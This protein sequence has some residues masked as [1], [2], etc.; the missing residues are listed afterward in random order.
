M[1]KGL[2]NSSKTDSTIEILFDGISCRE[3]QQLALTVDNCG[4]IH[5]GGGGD[6]VV[7]FA[8]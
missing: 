2:L 4:S 7:G 3:G 1:R 5:D 6:S 8:S